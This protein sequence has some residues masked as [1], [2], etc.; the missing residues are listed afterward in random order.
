M[1]TKKYKIALDARPLSTPVSGVGRLIGEILY[2]FPEKEKYEFHLFSHLPLHPTHSKVL[3]LPNV[4]LKIGKGFFA[5]KGGLYFLVTL[6]SEIRKGKFDLFWGS[7][8]VAPFFLPRKLPVVLTYCDLVLYLYPQTMRK[9]A[10]IQQRVFQYYSVKRANFILSISENTR[11]D[12]IQKFK[13]PEELTSVSYPGIDLNEIKNYLQVKPSEKVKQLPPNFLLSVSTIEPRK[14]YSFLL[15]VFQEYRNISS[16]HLTWVIVGKKGWESK[17]FY[18]Q[19]N[20]EIQKHKDIIL[21]EGVND[22]DLH[23]IY[24]HA[25]L[26]LFAS[27]YEGFRIPLL[28]A[29]AHNK[30]CLVSDIPTFHEIG[31]DQIEYLPTDDPKRWANK[32]VELQQS[33]KLPQIDLNFFSWENA[34]IQTKKAFDRFLK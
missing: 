14:N 31:S 1:K 26:F 15:K 24:S 33:K 17:E 8:Q 30:K 34:A 23:H 29:L 12:Q 28:E 18:F 21:L 27:H 19:L 6:P 32:I 11:K 16:N 3:E 13:Y 2:H 10:Q 9:I 20:E 5:K 4:I 25:S 7:Q 22:I